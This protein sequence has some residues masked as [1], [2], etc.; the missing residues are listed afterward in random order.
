MKKLQEMAL[1][2][3]E[4]LKAEKENSK[5]FTGVF[6]KCL[7]PCSDTDMMMFNVLINKTNHKGEPASKDLM[8]VSTYFLM[9]KYLALY[10]LTAYAGY[11]FLNYLD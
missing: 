8:T 5:S 7:L 10:P 4:N 9:T 6:L 11:T 2:A 1:E 3:G